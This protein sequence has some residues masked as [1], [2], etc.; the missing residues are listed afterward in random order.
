MEKKEQEERK[1]GRGWIYIASR[2][3]KID[4]KS[5]RDRDGA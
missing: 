3:R 5:G 1:R 2:S 4:R